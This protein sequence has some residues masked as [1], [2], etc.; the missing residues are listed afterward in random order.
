VHVVNGR[1]VMVLTGLRQKTETGEAPLTRGRLQFQSEG[2]EVFYRRI[3]LR[4]IR[5]IPF[6][7]SARS[8][9]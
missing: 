7:F 6:P 2:A 4:P 1:S 9:A 8:A 3:A 5:E